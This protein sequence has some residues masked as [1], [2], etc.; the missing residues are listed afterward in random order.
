MSRFI[1]VLLLSVLCALAA[2]GRA[3][4]P[5]GAQ[6]EV[7]IAV[8]DSGIDASHPDLAGQ[9]VP[10]FDFIDND[11]EADDLVGHGTEMAGIIAANG[12]VQGV[13]PD[14]RVMPL[15][16]TDL[17]GFVDQRT[18][19]NAI[20]YAASQ[21]ADVVFVG[22]GSVGVTA[23][24]A[25]AVANAE[26]AGIPVIAPAGNLAVTHTLY[27]GALPTVVSVVAVD[28]NGM[29]LP[30]SNTSGRDMV[31]AP[32]R[33][34]LTTT[35][36]GE[37]LT[38]S[39]SS[40]AAAH[41][42]GVAGLALTVE[43][44]LT[45]T[46]V[47]QILRHSTD[48]LP[49]DHWYEYFE[50]GQINATKAVA[51]ASTT[52]KDVAVTRLTVFPSRPLGAQAN[53]VRVRIVNQ[54]NV[55]TGP[56]TLDVT[57]DGASV[58]LTNLPSLALG[59][60]T[61]VDVPLPMGSPG[62]IVPVVGTVQP[63]AG[64]TETAN[65]SASAN[66]NY[67]NEV[68]HDV[69]L[70]IGELS[71]P[72]VEAG[73]ITFPITV[74]NR[75]NQDEPFVTVRIFVDDEEIATQSFSLAVAEQASMPG[76]WTISP[77]EPARLRVLRVLASIPDPDI[78]PE[79]NEW[80]HAFAVGLRDDPA[81]LQYADIPGTDIV[82]DAPW[83][84]IRSYVPVL[85][86]VPEFPASRW[87][88]YTIERI[89]VRNYEITDGD[90][91]P[92]GPEIAIDRREGEDGGS[93]WKDEDFQI[94]RDDGWVHL[95]GGI[96]V[97]EEFDSF[98]HYIMRVP[99]KCVGLDQKKGTQGTHYLY[100]EVKWSPVILL[101][102]LPFPHTNSRVLR[103]LFDKK[104]FPKFDLADRYY[105][106][107]VHTIAEQTT[108][109]LPLAPKKN[110]GGPIAML[111]ESSYALGLVDTQLCCG[112]WAAFKDKVVVTDHNV[113]Y[114]TDYDPPSVPKYGP[115]STIEAWMEL[116]WYRGNLGRL[117]GEEVTLQ[118]ARTQEDA[119]NLK[120]LGHHL[121]TYDTGHIEGPWHGGGFLGGDPNPNTIDVVLRAMQ[122]YNA[123]GFAYAAHPNLEAHKWPQAYLD[124]AIGLPAGKYSRTDPQVNSL[125]KDFIF[126]GLQVWN[127][128]PDQVAKAGKL[129]AGER[130]HMD[131]F[132]GPSESQR[133]TANPAWDRELEDSLK[134]YYEQVRRG[135]IYFFKDADKEKF[136]RKIYMSAG[137]D[138]HGDFNYA[139]D[140]EATAIAFITSLVRATSPAALLF[141]RH[142]TFSMDSNAYAR[143]RT[144]MLVHDRPS[145]GDDG[146]T[147]H[148][149]FR[150]GNTILTDGPV[151]KF[152]LDSDGR[153]NPPGGA[154]RW[155]D[156]PATWRW[157][158][159]EGKIGG[160]GVFDGGRTLLVPV[161]SE[162][163]G[164]NV[165]IESVWKKSA[166]P[167]IGDTLV[168]RIV[169]QTV[170]SRDYF[171]LGAG[172]P[173]EG[174]HQ[175]LPRTI[176]KMAALVMRGRH[177]PE[178]EQCITNPVWAVPVQIDVFRTGECP[179]E[180]GEIQVVF[181]FPISMTN[182]G[183]RII[184]F[185]RPL[186]GSGNST[187]PEVPLRPSPGW[188]EDKRVTNGKYTATNEG[189]VDCSP[190]DW[191]ANTH[192]SE[193]GF[194]SWVVYMT[195]PTDLHGNL[196]NDI[197][198][199]FVEQLLEVDYFP[200]YKAE[201]TLSSPFG[202]E[203]AT[204]TGPTTVEVNFTTL[205]DADSDG[206]EEVQT[207]IVQMELT[208]TSA[209]L[210]PVTLRLRDP[211]KHPF[212]RSTGE[213]EETTNDT[214]GVLDVPPFT[215]TGTADSFF[216]VFFEIEVA[217][218]GLVL[219]NHDPK[220]PTTTIT[221]KPPAPG[222]TYESLQVI[223]LFDES[224]SS[225]EWEVTANRD[226]PTPSVGRGG[227]AEAVGGDSP[228]GSIAPA[229]GSGSAAPPYGAIAGGAA[230]A[231]V[232][233]AAGGWYATRRW[234]R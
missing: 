136:I 73:T 104:P 5:V 55:A 167:D 141:A 133:F 197:G 49:I 154:A 95:D 212:H 149:A 43:P 202:P 195:S 226:T 96:D 65:N 165:W 119:L 159:A 68:V 11:T 124:Q 52:Y 38:T 218:L 135:L 138:A 213:I 186:D 32:G 204:L 67:T 206:R 2:V 103:V 27:P 156:D 76:S 224:E 10:G 143:V 14:C 208:G 205:G 51:R 18:L 24:V 19:A 174:K 196:L 209:L 75:G 181:H 89:T 228:E 45:V 210:G 179:Y 182:T 88:T 184:A 142:D 214:P 163:R 70:D 229:R 86:F 164:D 148:E 80:F 36:G 87:L 54:G 187:D 161:W 35:L 90:G 42:A 112:D 131:P 216:D 56:L 221:H 145:S 16:V 130:Q 63:L 169:E 177:Y 160:L 144:Y 137:T 8:I 155:H 100:A 158:N 150:E 198:R 173:D 25:S 34:L 176:D 225:T 97:D 171:P 46:Q 157:E 113:F 7:V 6:P 91:K 219:H 15:K 47:R 170:D 62:A 211:A 109:R 222:E 28:E 4:A 64:E 106:A 200:R 183:E 110:Y 114:S 162:S 93:C 58:G 17:E 48:P 13:C 139:D 118:S 31:A 129:R 188:E 172:A 85:F 77:A 191:D 215:A 194:K 147:S 50:Y 203:T 168:Y 81:L 9:L 121:L 29:L 234:L 190:G 125:G 111:L 72:V 83:K 98:W 74:R 132:A 3:N 189:R 193:P 44:T 233:I 23:D 101:A 151:C 33:D 107:H 37:T 232:A 26:A 40:A 152:N 217:D 117:A 199:T 1:K 123:T 126:K 69:D 231:A 102:K 59:E 128:K 153:H 116:G 30:S 201:V 127:R 82:I 99:L 207:E 94:V 192:A 115:T 79:S 61:E 20:D 140:L 166:T 71:E 230:V 92:V 78:D 60:A 180:P 39:G 53:F 227:I 122:G 105:D 175:L 220:H 185:V 134:T 146:A 21:N 12:T 22:A 84:T 120:K 108:S 66:V 223:P 41:L 178:G 57:W